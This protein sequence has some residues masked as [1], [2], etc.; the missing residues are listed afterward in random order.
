MGVTLFKTADDEKVVSTAIIAE[1]ED[2]EE[3]LA[4]QDNNPIS[5]NNDTASAQPQTEEVSPVSQE[6]KGEQTSDVKSDLF[7]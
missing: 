4:T 5:E 7:E 1:N 6:E 3:V 2:E